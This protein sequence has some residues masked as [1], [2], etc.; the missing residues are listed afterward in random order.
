VGAKPETIAP[1]I[2]AMKAEMEALKTSGSKLEALN[3]E[4]DAKIKTVE[5][6]FRC[7]A[8]RVNSKHR[9]S[10]GRLNK[11]RNNGKCVNQA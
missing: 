8:C 10:D 11:D 5:A 6:I 4:P 7:A 2:A 9:S 3:V 1:K